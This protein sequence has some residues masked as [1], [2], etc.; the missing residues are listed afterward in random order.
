MERYCWRSRR[1]AGERGAL[2]PRFRHVA[3]WLMSGRLGIVPFYEI[4]S[5]KELSSGELLVEG[6]QRFALTPKELL[7]QKPGAGS[8]R[9]CSALAC[10]VGPRLSV[11]S[12]GPGRL[13]VDA[14]EELGA[15]DEDALER[16]VIRRARRAEDFH[17]HADGLG[18]HSDL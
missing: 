5:T 17:H 3:E 7:C 2:S 11:L 14:H 13:A 12:R 1:H 8:R 10:A 18:F 6:I 4:G 15:R 9:R 16:A